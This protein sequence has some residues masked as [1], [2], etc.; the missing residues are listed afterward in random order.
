MPWG[1][2][3]GR[4]WN[5]ATEA[6][7][8]AAQAT[9]RGVG[10]A[11]TATKET[12]SQAA[13]WAE[14][15]AREAAR[16]KMR[17][18][19]D[20]AFDGLAKPAEAGRRGVAGAKKGAAAVQSGYN[21]VKQ[22]FTGKPAGSPVQPCPGTT[23]TP[24]NDPAKDGWVI[25]PQGKGKPCLTY[26][27]PPKQ[28][29]AQARAKAV[30]PQSDCC[31][32]QRAGKPPRDIIYVNGIK[33]TAQTHCDTLNA[34]A[35]QTCG[36]V[37]GV[38]NATDGGMLDAAQTGQDRR[39]IKAAHAGKGVPAGDGRNPAVDT[40]SRTISDELRAGRKPEIWAHSQGGAVTSLA[41]LDAKNER[42]AATRN[43]D[44]LRGMT[45]KSMGSAAPAWTDGP[46]YEHF[47]QVNDATPSLFGLG[48]S[49]AGDAAN[50]GRG[51]VVHRFAGPEKGPFQTVS[52]RL[53]WKPEMTANHD[54][55]KTYLAMEKQVHG[56]C[57]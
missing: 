33:T 23:A 57:S 6:G 4:A 18:V 24:G 17:G 39:L 42:I 15:K 48:H 22:V 2:A 45:V 5:A 28:A 3:F 49:P 35:A 47:I 30:V 43:P 41:L 14:Q 36:R 34:I 12:A 55:E 54:V 29:M 10:R 44:P 27:P 25:A 1:S 7:R 21:R 50:A 37:V 52:P 51:A 8:A 9:A 38:Y 31:A 56:G 40:L 16:D 53:D 20:G 46:N 26:P 32:R 19:A 11:W 13:S